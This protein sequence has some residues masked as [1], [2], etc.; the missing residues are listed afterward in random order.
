M[1]PAGSWLSPR[2][3]LRLTENPGPATLDLFPCT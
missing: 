2:A 3:T 1:N